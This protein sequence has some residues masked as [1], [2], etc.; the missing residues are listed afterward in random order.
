MTTTTDAPFI[1]CPHLGC[2]YAFPRVI[3]FQS[4]I[5]QHLVTLHTADQNKYL[6]P[7]DLHKLHCFTCPHCPLIF[8]TVAKQKLHTQKVHPTTRGKLNIDIILSTYP[9]HPNCSQHKSNW[10]KTLQWITP[11]HI[12]PATARSSLYTKLSPKHRQTCFHTFHHLLNWC[13][14]ASLPGPNDPSIPTFQTT[15]TPFWK[16]LLLFESIILAPSPNKPS[17]GSYSTL[18]KLRLTR[19]RSGNIQELYYDSRPNL[20]TPTQPL[21]PPVFNDLK[22]NK[23]AQQC[24]DQ[25]NLHTAFARISSITPTATLTPHYLNILKKLYPPPIP[26]NTTNSHNTRSKLRTDLNLPTISQGNI[27]K[28]LRRLK[29]GTATG[30]FAT[31]IDLLKDYALHSTTQETQTIFP[32]LQTFTQLIHTIAHNKVPAT[33]KPYLSAQYVVALH[34]DPNNLDKL[35]PIGIGTA[36]RRITAACLM[37]Q[38]GSTIAEV[39]LPH[40]QLGIAISGGLDFICHSTQAQLETFMPTPQASTRALLSLD[41]E[42]MFNAI[43]RGAC[44]QQLHN[45]PKLQPLLP[46]FDLLYANPNTCWHK[47]PINHFDNF[48]QWEGFAQG[49]PL[50][51][52]FADIVLATVL[53]P[54]NQQLQARVRQR[55]KSQP[56]PVTLSY[57][58]DTS[59]VLPYED[60]PWFITTFQTLGNPVGIRLNLIK[61]QILT[62]LSDE[63]PMK[64]LNSAQQEALSQAL[65]MLGP[66]AEQRQGIRLLGQ[67]IGSQAFANTFIQDRIST[68]H[69]TINTK[70]FH[71]I[72]DSQ[73]QLAMLKNCIIPSVQH[74]LA[75]HVYHTFTPNSPQDLHQWHSSTTLQLRITIQNTVASLTQCDLLPFHTTWIIHLPALLGGLGIR[76]PTATAIPAALTTFTRSIRYAIH[77]IPCNGQPIPMPP[78]HNHCFQNTAHKPILSHYGQELLPRL[79]QQPYAWKTIEHFVKD[80]PLHGIQKHLY[81]QHQL[82]VKKHLPMHFPPDMAQLLPSLISPLTSIPLLS[83]SRRIV[84]NRI[85][86][87][88]FRILLQRKLRLPILPPSLHYTP[89]ICRAHTP[90][91]PFGD[92]LFSCTNASKTP[93][94][95]HLRNT[96]YHIL[97]K[98]APLASLV[99]TPTDIQLEP[100]NTIPLYP[101]LRPAD[102]GLQLTPTPQNNHDESAPLLALDVTFTHTPRTASPHSSDRPDS[103]NNTNKVHDESARQKF[104]VPHAYA[105]LTHNIILLPFTIDHL[106]GLGSFATNFLF[107]EP[108]TA[109]IPTA[110][111]PPKWT[112]Q[113]FPRNPDAYLLYLRTLEKCPTNILHSANHNWNMGAQVKR[114]FGSTYHTATPSAWAIQTLGLNLVKA[115][116]HHCYNTTEKISHHAATQRPLYKN[117]HISLPTLSSPTFNYL[118]VTDPCYFLPTDPFTPPQD[119]TED[120]TTLPIQ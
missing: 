71:R 95:N 25:D 38:F 104:N 19:F 64:H 79:P 113:S 89:C 65:S 82:E 118:R 100:P 116:A 114:P 107:G 99:A 53:Q 93:I 27:L 98:I 74:L 44:R 58:D 76:D 62:S 20:D 30:P 117:H 97:A 4:Q 120:T 83:L 60:I 29:R 87:H 49:C 72:H 7:S 101:T 108:T 10:L 17:Q 90:L 40:G 21:V 3:G 47:S 85:P 115:L 31:S 111:S 32:Y 51:G 6:T 14:E 5:R 69:D 75:T 68:I 57:H 35:R 33:V 77:G 56:P 18:L 66:K 110:S 23:H 15:S 8:A 88:H 41:I 109:I 24:A 73:T 59:I 2:P 11:L 9:E 86:N 48:P 81:H 80:A 55:H 1:P 22:Y 26:F 106:G 112:P 94:H 46:F 52:A 61:T 54:L 84:A 16:L 28:T 102:I 92:H 103:N 67:P 39:L 12:T 105:L 78:I 34:K 36:L 50:S 37:T 43:S 96:C 91:D 63:S 70:L 42:N 45:N 13:I 119:T